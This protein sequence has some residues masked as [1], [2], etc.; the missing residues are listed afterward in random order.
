MTLLEAEEFIVI[1][2]G[3]GDVMDVREVMKKYPDMTLHQ[4]LLDFFFEV[5]P[6]GDGLEYFIGKR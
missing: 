6:F 5:A 4:A 1:V 3:Q 2:M